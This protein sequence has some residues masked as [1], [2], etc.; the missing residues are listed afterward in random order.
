[1]PNLS[2]M[3]KTYY[4][5]LE[6]SPRAEPDEI[7]KAYRKMAKTAHP[8]VNSSPDAQDKFVIITEAY[9][10][11][12]DPEKR[13]VYDSRLRRDRVQSTAAR[14]ARN[15]TAGSARANQERYEAWVRQARARAQANARMSYND[16]KNKSRVEKA[17]LEVFHYMQYFLIFLVFFIATLL[18]LIPIIAM[19]YGRWWLVFLALIM[20]PVSMKIMEQCKKNWKEL[21]S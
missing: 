13:S 19:I 14:A 3:R 5:V 7:R 8:D 4:Q 20:T 17:E 10:I 16:F 6:V 15:T 9:E 18:M 11:L 1:M 12:S 21:N 2:I